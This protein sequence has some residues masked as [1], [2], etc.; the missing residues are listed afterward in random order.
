MLSHASINARKSASAT[1]GGKS[2]G[3]A[4]GAPEDETC[5]ISAEINVFVIG[6]SPFPPALMPNPCRMSFCRGRGLENR[7]L[8]L[9]LVR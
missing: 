5:G 7:I 4:V 2:V 9:W 6:S 8:S 1:I 3:Q